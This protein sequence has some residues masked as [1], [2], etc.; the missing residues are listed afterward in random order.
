MAEDERKRNEK[1]CMDKIQGQIDYLEILYS[2]SHFEPLKKLYLSSFLELH[3][4]F[5]K[6]KNR[7][8]TS[9][10]ILKI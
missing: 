4:K 8:V 9:L 1:E 10:V 6:I 2:V 3:R 7:K 5:L